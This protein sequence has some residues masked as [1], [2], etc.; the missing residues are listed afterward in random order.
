MKK[1]E[2]IKQINANN[3]VCAELHEV[4]TNNSYR[5]NTQ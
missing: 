1:N 3:K 5:E 4:G 2:N